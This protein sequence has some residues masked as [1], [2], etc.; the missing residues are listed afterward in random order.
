M[1]SVTTPSYTRT[2]SSLSKTNDEEKEKPKTYTR[3]YS[4]LGRDKASEDEKAKSSTYTR[5]YSTLARTK[6]EEKEK[7]K[8]EPSPPKRL[9]SRYSSTKDLSAETKSRLSSTYGTAKKEEKGPPITFNT[10]YKVASTRSRSRD[11][12]PSTDT[13]NVPQTA[14]QRLTAQ[15]DRSRDPSPASKPVSAYSRI[16]T[17]R[18]RD[19]SPV[20]KSYSDSVQDKSALNRTYS[21]NTLGTKEAKPISRTYS[22]NVSGA[23]DQLE[24]CYNSIL[25]ARDKSRDPSPVVSRRPSITSSYSRGSRD[26]SPVD[27]K[28]L[29]LSSYRLSN[30]REKSR[31]PSPSITL[32]KTKA[33]ESSPSLTTYRRPSREPSPVD[34]LSKYGRTLSGGKTTTAAS[35]SSQLKNPDI[36][37]SYMTSSEA[38]TRP[39]R[40]SYI[41]RHSPQ[42]EKLETPSMIP[43]RVESP[44]KVVPAVVVESKPLAVESDSDS[45]ETSSSEQSDASCGEEIKKP[46]TKIMIQVTTITRGTSPTPPGTTCPRVRR[47]EVAK[48]VEKVR[49][50]ALQ[51]PP[52]CDKSSQSDR[53]DDSTRYSRYGITSRAAYSPYSPSPTS[54]SSRYSS[55]LTTSRYSREPSENLSAAESEKSESSEKTSQRSD[56]FNFALPKSKEG[57]PVKSET[58]SSSLAN[59][60]SQ[61]KISVS[62]ERARA[63]ASKS[64]TPDSGKSLPPQSPTKTDAPKISSPKVSNK[65]F[66]KSALNMGPTDRV[67]RSKS[68]SSDN[69]SPTVEKTRLQFQQLVNGDAAIRPSAERSA[70]VD[71]DSSTESVELES[72]IEQKPAEPTKEE[73]ISHKVEEAK[74]FLLK[75]LG[76][77]AAVNSLKSL[78]PSAE[79]KA[80]YD[81]SRSESSFAT[82]NTETCSTN[83]PTQTASKLLDLDFSSLQKSTSGEKPWWMEDSNDTQDDNELTITEDESTQEVANKLLNGFSE[84]AI[85]PPDDSQDAK[86]SWMNANGLSLNESLQKLERVQS[87]EKAWWCQSPEDKNTSDNQAVAQNVDNAPGNNNMWEQETQADISEL[88]QDDEIRE[89]EGNY[90]LTGKRSF[91][92]GFNLSSAQLGDRA[93]P[94]GIE[95]SMNDRKSPYDNIQG[96]NYQKDKLQDFNARPRLFISRHTNIDDLLGE[97][98]F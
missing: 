78:S 76:N 42:K 21:N 98:Q 55:G 22:S 44:L 46:E 58:R 23:R 33:R 37:I 48:T 61:S 36:S 26:S 60:S 70:S 31:D 12:S 53:M 30:G 29:S 9:S 18:S 69:T 89:I 77:A 2:Y 15:R 84:L 86:W 35:T 47:I 68:S 7:E 80:W 72:Q 93:S 91:H 94:E 8:K 71:S 87:G 43:K 14:L 51:G 88:Q 17:A 16:S 75:T 74:S 65:D 5:S 52:M 45:D 54:Y 1:S 83:Y 4:N 57:S 11:P 90:R 13:S 97:K 49:Q 24:K 50:R 38:N 73:I 95:S 41:N 79:S 66:R 59:S 3:T 67:S 64:K 20:S 56:K 6:A 96:N 19:P 92:N 62:K 32:N 25:S 39:S 10:R 28:Y 82:D 27:S 63:S 34:T 40:V 81:D 85:N